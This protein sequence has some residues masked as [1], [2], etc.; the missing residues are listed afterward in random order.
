MKTF[1]TAL[2]AATLLVTLGT[3]ALA[4][5]P[6][7]LRGTLSLSGAWAIYPLA[8]KWGEAFTKKYPDVKLDISAGGAGKGMTD[9]LAGAVEIG[10]VSREVDRAEKAKGAFPIFIA[11]D[12]VFPTASAKNPA[13]AQLQAKGLSVKTFTDIYITGRVTSWR[14]AVGGPHAPIHVYTRSDACGAASAWAAATAAAPS[15]ARTS[16]A[17]A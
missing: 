13:L 11:K 16:R 8:V 10:M 9:V 3:T 14:Q 6:Q 17:A 12:G 2:V 1:L 4:Q 15:P 7:H 5:P